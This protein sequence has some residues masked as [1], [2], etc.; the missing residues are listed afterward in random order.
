M[1]Y[2]AS[3]TNEFVSAAIY[4]ENNSYQVEVSEIGGPSY[5]VATFPYSPSEPET[6]QLAR[7]SAYAKM[8]RAVEFG[9]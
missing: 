6:A 7:T 4:R 1:T 2:I 3:K 5:V 9:E 8:R